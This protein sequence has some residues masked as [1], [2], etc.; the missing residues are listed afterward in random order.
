MCPSARGGS[1][2]R[3]LRASCCRHWA[4]ARAR[5]QGP[6]PHRALHLPEQEHAAV[7]G[8]EAVHNAIRVPGAPAAAPATTAAPAAARRELQEACVA[9]RL[10]LP[11]CAGGTGGTGGGGGAHPG[12]RLRLPASTH[13][14]PGC[15]CCAGGCPAAGA[16]GGLARRSSGSATRPDACRL[17]HRPACSSRCCRPSSAG[18]LHSRCAQTAG[19]NLQRALQGALRKHRVNHSETDVSG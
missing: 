10:L 6:Q 14:W 1:C 3:P 13:C 15:C 4:L 17:A 19:S 8:D 18:H 2:C 16:G 9:S 7:G 11:R 5:Q 12:C